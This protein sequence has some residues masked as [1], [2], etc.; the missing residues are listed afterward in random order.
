L[1]IVVVIFSELEIQ[2]KIDAAVMQRQKALASKSNSNRFKKA[3]T[4]NTDDSEYLQQKN[5]FEQLSGSKGDGGSKW[6]VR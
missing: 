6:L 5:N 2:A 1:W 4:S 3:E